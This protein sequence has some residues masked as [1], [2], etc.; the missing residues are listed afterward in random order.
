MRLTLAAIGGL[1]LDTGVADK[2]IFDDDV[3]GLRHSR[4]R[5]RGP[6][7]D[8]SVQDRRQDPEACPRTC[9]GD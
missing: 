3:S 6:Y 4:A 9:H 5:Q 2:I 1:K 7:V 8:L